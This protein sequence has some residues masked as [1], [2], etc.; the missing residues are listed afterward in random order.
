MKATTFIDWMWDTNAHA[1]FPA[2]YQHKDWKED[3][4]ELVRMEKYG[5][6]WDSRYSDRKCKGMEYKP[7][8]EEASQW[9]LENSVPEIDKFTCLGVKIHEEGVG[10]E[11]KENRWKEDQEN[12]IQY[13]ISEGNRSANNRE[14]GR[15]L[16][17]GIAVLYCL[18]ESWITYYWEGDHLKLERS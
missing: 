9:V 10:G 7:V 15:S 11:T 3:M 5:R 12:D 6:E 8:Q 18:Y 13:I 2:R 16:W 4:E 1:P 17:K 14:I